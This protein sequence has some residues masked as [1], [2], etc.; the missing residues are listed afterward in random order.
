ML[1]L[2]QFTHYSYRASLL[3][4]I[5]IYIYIASL[6]LAVV[7]HMDMLLHKICIYISTVLVLALLFEYILVKYI[8]VLQVYFSLD[9]FVHILL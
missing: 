4:L 6:S 3:F 1:K 2:I 8:P 5:L 7:L 9:S